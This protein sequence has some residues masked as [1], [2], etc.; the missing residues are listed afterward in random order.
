MVGVRGSAGTEVGVG[1]ISAIWSRSKSS[2]TAA[3][4]EFLSPGATEWRLTWD[5]SP[6]RSHLL[7]IA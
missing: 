6:H 4:R 7:R 3:R 1:W 5:R 2:S